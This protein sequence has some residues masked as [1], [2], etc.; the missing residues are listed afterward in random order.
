MFLG[1]DKSEKSKRRTKTIG[2]SCDPH[3]NQPFVY[4]PL[5]RAELK[6]RAL[7]ISVWDYDRFMANDFLG[8][9]SEQFISLINSFKHYS[10]I[11]Y[12]I[13]TDK[14]SNWN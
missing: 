12:I 9:V 7:E 1:P 6:T 13:Y 2:G 3:W 14:F 10:G 5:R 4:C 8:E 11:K